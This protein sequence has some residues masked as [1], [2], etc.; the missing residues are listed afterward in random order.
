M[1]M[2]TQTPAAPP[3]ARGLKAPDRSP[4]RP[5]APTRRWGHTSCRPGAPTRRWGHRLSKLTFIL[6]AA[7]LMASLNLYAAKK[8][9][10]KM[11]PPPKIP[12]GKA[13][14]FELEPRGVQ[15]GV[16]ARIKL[17]GT[18]LIGLTEL[19][20]HDARVKGRLLSDPPI[21]TNEAWIEITAAPGLPRGP[22]EISVKNTNSESSKLKLYVDDL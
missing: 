11:A 7:L 16:T 14:I 17:I 6:L 8:K 9:P 10:A 3:E 12:P 13:E 18:N 15:R 5:G 22:Y 21:T 1:I 19:K 20:L 4:C 2:K